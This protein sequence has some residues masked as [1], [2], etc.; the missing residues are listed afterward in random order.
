MRVLLRAALA[1][2]CCALGV[3][4]GDN[5]SGQRLQTA[6]VAESNQPAY[7]WKASPAGNSAELLTL[8]CRS[9]QATDAG[10][11]DVP[12]VAVLRDTLGDRN[13]ENDRLTYVWLLS[14]SRLNLG[15]HILSAVP[16][17]YWRVGN[18]SQSEN[19]RDI[20]PLMDLSAPQHPVMSEVGHD[21]FQWMMLD[22][23]TMFVRATSRAYRANAIDYERL[24]LEEAIGYLRQAPVSDDTSG[25]TRKQLDIVIARLEL[26]KRLL[27]GLVTER[28][29]AEVGQE[30]NFEQERIR[31]RNWELL[32]QCAER[33]GLLFEP[34]DVAGETGQYAILWF[35]LQR[36]W[37]PAGTSLSAVWKLLNI[38]NPWTDGRLKTWHGT[39]YHRAIDGGS[40]S[41]VP[42]GVY[43]L[44]YPRAPLLLIDFRDELHV[45]R[46]EMTQRSI[47]EITAGVIGI[48]HFTNWYYY[49][50]A[51]LYNFVV[52]RHGGAVNQAARLD[53]YSQLRI[54]LALDSQLDAGLRK[55]M[56][57]RLDSLALNPLEAAPSRE[58]EAAKTRYNQLETEAQGDGRL[59]E[60]LDK[61][62][63]AELASF[64]QTRKAQ[65]ATLLLHDLTFGAYTHRAKKDDENLALLDCYR[66]VEY[67]LDFLDTLA[68]AGT[69]PE[70]AY[71]SSRIRE[72]VTELSSLIGRVQ[73]SKVRSHA[74]ATLS[75]LEELSQDAGL[76]ADCSSALVAID[77][78]NAAI[79]AAATQGAVAVTR[80]IAVPP[81]SGIPESNK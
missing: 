70:I 18:G 34:L 77:R 28:R 48:S 30:S 61:E 68:A 25:L 1:T 21:I 49:V 23:T 16:F 22:P 14:Y 78:G 39:S 19:A 80:T 62:R 6:S 57:K 38:T 67:Q 46:H 5:V 52:A 55:D 41:L 60:R 72:S 64:G 47:N 12:L 3:C 53:C 76:R 4:L 50:G 8:F 42:L 58:V 37:T 29:A 74:A 79:R 54:E 26:R 17:F 44:N 43:S 24:H 32:R 75:R 63:R 71:D 56:Q 45:R 51:D 59:L 10:Q 66:R 9:C 11:T 31:T 33:T 40:S 27:G 73:S 36:E 7:Y 15:Q 69:Q 35:P 65:I 2:F 13:P 20:P 81:A